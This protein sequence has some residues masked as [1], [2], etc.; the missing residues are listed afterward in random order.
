MPIGIEGSVVLHRET[1]LQPHSAAYD[2]QHP[3]VELAKMETAVRS[4][5]KKILRGL[6]GRYG[7]TTKKKKKKD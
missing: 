7:S 4:E 2:L 1:T 3:A 5:E 6:E